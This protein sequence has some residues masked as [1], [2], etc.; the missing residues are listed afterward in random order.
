[1]GLWRLTILDLGF[2]VSTPKQFPGSEGNC[3]SNGGVFGMTSGCCISLSLLA[4]HSS[5]VRTPE[6]ARAA[7][8]RRVEPLMSAMVVQG[9]SAR[10]RTR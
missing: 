8:S 1:M 7:M 5:T 9:E 2:L 6:V 10:V 3:R 4:F